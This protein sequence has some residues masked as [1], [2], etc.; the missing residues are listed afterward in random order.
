MGQQEVPFRS[1]KITL[2]EQAID[3]LDDLKKRGRYRSYSMAIEEVI[4]AMYG[5]VQD[6]EVA[7]ILGKGKTPIPEDLKLQAFR[8]IVIRLYRFLT[9]K[10]SKT[11]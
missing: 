4:R 2:S 9:F 5:V 10:K 11:S 8:D 6:I 7:D 3:L 1:M